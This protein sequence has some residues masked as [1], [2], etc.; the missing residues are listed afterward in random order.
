MYALAKW[1]LNSA[2]FLFSVGKAWYSKMAVGYSTVRWIAVSVLSIKL[3]FDRLEDCYVLSV[4]AKPA[5]T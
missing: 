3:L 1:L 2:Q 5:Y 4:T